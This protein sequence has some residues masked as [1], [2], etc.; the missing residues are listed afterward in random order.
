MSYKNVLLS[1][2]LAGVL[3]LS[4]LT[5][6]NITE[7]S[8]VLQEPRMDNVMMRSGTYK[9]AGDTALRLDLYYPPGYEERS[10]LPAVIFNNGVGSMTLP[11]WRGYRDWAK[12][13]ALRNLIAVH[14]QSRRRRAGA[15][16]R[17][18]LTYLRENAA[19][20]G[21]DRDR[22][23]IWTSSA[24][25]AVGLPLAM[26]PERKYI[27]CAVVYYG[28][29][30]VDSM[31]QD[32]PLMIVRA[33]L[34]SYA[35]NRNIEEMV[36]RALDRDIP[37]QLVNYLHGQHAFDILDDTDRSREVI[38]QTLEFLEHNLADTAG[39]GDAHLFTARNFYAMVKKG[40][41]DRA[42]RLYKEAYRQNLNDPRFN[43]FMNRATA[44]RSLNNIGYQ[45]LDEGKPK[46]AVAVFELMAETFPDSPNAY[47]SMADGY[48]AAGRKERAIRY[49]KR[50]LE[51]LEETELRDVVERAIRE[52]AESRLKRL[53]GDNR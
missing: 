52:S 50:A 40:E 38:R 36:G 24:N 30:R 45:L 51:L 28:S 9:S 47:D 29:A 6:Q 34:D 2:L 35:T 31:R 19:E 15:D 25:V 22:I 11:D 16:S 4:T 49:S 7:M 27:R 26:E 8:L 42:I 21:I 20:L 1:L 14:Y 37:F 48:E 46:L 41:V 10:N 44:E 53:E 39:Y 3:P 17:D 13:V 32:L 18:L 23:A 43:R 33:G 12:L 5:A